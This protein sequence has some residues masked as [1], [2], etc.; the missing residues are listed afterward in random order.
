MKKNYDVTY[1]PHTVPNAQMSRNIQ[2][3]VLYYKNKETVYFLKLSKTCV[4][5]KI[6]I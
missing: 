5:I 2:W 1:Y 3:S 6:Y 4:I